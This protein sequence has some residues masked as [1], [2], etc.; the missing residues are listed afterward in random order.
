MTFKT[1]V[2]I[3]K[4]AKT[5]TEIRG[6]SCLDQHRLAKEVEAFFGRQGKLKLGPLP[7]SGRCTGVG[8]WRRYWY[9]LVAR[10]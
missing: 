7:L 3:N 8:F 2:A 6:I 1:S 4:G 10:G 9:V 5:V